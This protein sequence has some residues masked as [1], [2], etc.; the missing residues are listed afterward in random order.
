MKIFVSSKL[1]ILVFC[2]A[3]VFGDLGVSE[4]PGVIGRRF[5][6]DYRTLKHPAPTRL[7]DHLAEI[8]IGLSSTTTKQPYRTKESLS[9]SDQHPCFL[10]DRSSA[11]LYYTYGYGTV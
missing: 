3:L 11:E 7:S 6:K 5:T 10:L 4:P 2:R 9:L 8:L 1:V